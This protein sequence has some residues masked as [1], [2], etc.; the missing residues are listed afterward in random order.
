[1]DIQM[2]EMNGY[3]ATREIRLSNHAQANII[4]IVAMTANVFDEDV[5]KCRAAG[6]NAH[7]GKPIDPEALAR[8]IASVL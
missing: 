2:P 6:M 3:D 4:P 7:L 5:D 8:T 1:M